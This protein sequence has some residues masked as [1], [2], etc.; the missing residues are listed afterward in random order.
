M[1]FLNISSLNQ[2]DRMQGSQNSIFVHIKFNRAWDSRPVSFS[3]SKINLV[4][5]RWRLVTHISPR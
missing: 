4:L 1:N 3:F 5:L 2:F